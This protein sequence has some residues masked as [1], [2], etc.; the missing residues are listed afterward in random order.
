[1]P[2]F[3]SAF[4]ATC[5][6][7]MASAVTTPA[8]ETLTIFGSCTVQVTAAP[9][10][11]TPDPSCTCACKGS[12]ALIASVEGDG[13]TTIVATSSVASGAVLLHDQFDS[14]T[15]TPG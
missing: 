5:D 2:D 6:V 12:W 7:P 1:M 11:G 8:P 9:G 14:A 13:L 4:A 10:T 15:P 3:P